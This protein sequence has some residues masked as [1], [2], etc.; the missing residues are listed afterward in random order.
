MSA[1]ILPFDGTAPDVAPSAW[2][3]PNATVIGAATIGEN[4][5]VWFNAVIRADG[6]TITVGPGSNVQDGCVLHA[7]PGLPLTLGAEVAVGHA[8]VLHGCTVAD[9]VLVGMHATIL[10][11]ATIG[12]G[13]LIAAGAVVLEGTDIPPRSLVA[14]VP[15]KVR[16]QTTDDE[17]AMIALNTAH[18]RNL[19]RQYAG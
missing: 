7:D 2:L 11:G 12:S 3:A 4:A 8:A 9:G 5:G 18:Y 17:V 1:L 14:G 16:R 10:N 13:S 19:A 6:D 15:A